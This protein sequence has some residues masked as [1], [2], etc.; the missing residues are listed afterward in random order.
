MKDDI[1]LHAGS[2]DEMGARFA[3]AGHTAERGDPVDCDHLTFLS[4][5]SLISVMS[6]KRLELLKRLRANGPM[7]VRALA[8]DLDRDYK[9][10]HGDVALLANAGLIERPSRDRVAVR[11]SRL[12]AELDL[13]A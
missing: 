13:A 4:L 5:Q 1:K 7:S 9:S 6:P 12:S 2:L 8:V 11:W 10:V 3:E